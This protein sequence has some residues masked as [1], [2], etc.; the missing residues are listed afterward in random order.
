MSKKKFIKKENLKKILKNPT[1]LNNFN[2]IHKKTQKIKKYQ[3]LSKSL[4]ISKD[5]TTKILFFS[6]KSKFSKEKKFSAK[7][8]TK[9]SSSFLN[10]RTMRF[11]QH[12]PEKKSGRFGKYQKSHF[13]QKIQT[14]L[15]KKICTHKRGGYHERDEVEGRRTKIL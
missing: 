13:F 11:D 9:K 3:K 12:N 14:F 4:K 8:K 5:L 2:K 15:R 6:K 7:N 1:K 10:I